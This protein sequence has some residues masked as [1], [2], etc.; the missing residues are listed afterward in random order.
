MSRMHI[1]VSEWQ[2]RLGEERL[3]KNREKAINGLSA[4]QKRACDYFED[5]LDAIA[6]EEAKRQEKKREVS[7]KETTKLEEKRQKAAHKFEDKMTRIDGRHKKR[8]MENP[9]N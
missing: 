9:S 2:R 8:D 5:D 4:K 7:A 6:K 3:T 1:A